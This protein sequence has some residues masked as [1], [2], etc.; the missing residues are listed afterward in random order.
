MPKQNKKQKKKKKIMKNWEILHF[1]S[2]TIIVHVPL[3]SESEKSVTSNMVDNPVWQMLLQM[4]VL[5]PY[6]NPQYCVWVITNTCTKDN[7]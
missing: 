3:F 1:I 5:L 4:R 7:V 2:L 6:E